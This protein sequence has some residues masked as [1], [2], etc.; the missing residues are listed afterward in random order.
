MS[1]AAVRT[2]EKN[3]AKKKVPDRVEVVED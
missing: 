3:M 1:G 2:I